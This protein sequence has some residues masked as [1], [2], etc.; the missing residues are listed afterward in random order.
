MKPK[1]SGTDDERDGPFELPDTHF[2]D[3]KPGFKPAEKG[4]KEDAS[5]GHHRFPRVSA[6]KDVPQEPLAHRIRKPE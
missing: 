4:Q 6:D 2:E 3:Q 5:E 1:K